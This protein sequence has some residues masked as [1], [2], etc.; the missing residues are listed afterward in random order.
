[1]SFTRQLQVW[2]EVGS[3]VWENEDRTVPKPAYQAFL[4]HRAI[5]LRERGLPGNEPLAPQN[6]Y[7]YTGFLDIKSKYQA[8]S[9]AFT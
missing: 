1:M 6:L 2:E 8:C 9:I 3:Q 5:L 7:N 4:E